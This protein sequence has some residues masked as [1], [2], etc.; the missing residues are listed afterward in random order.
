MLL[1]SHMCV[2]IHVHMHLPSSL[3]CAHTGLCT[4]MCAHAHVCVGSS[5]PIELRHPGSHPT[6]PPQ[7]QPLGSLLCTHS[8]ACMGRHLRHPCTY[9]CIHTH[10]PSNPG[11][12]QAGPPAPHGLSPGGRCEARAGRSGPGVGAGSPQWGSGGVT[13]APGHAGTPPAPPVPPAA[14]P[15]APAAAACSSLGGQRR[16]GGSRGQL[17]VGGPGSCPSLWPRRTRDPCSPGLGP[18][19]APAQARG[20]PYAPPP[21]LQRG[22][23]CWGVM[24]SEAS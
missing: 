16:T 23:P 5:L 19:A 7:S 13:P 4:H 15:L 2:P 10:V 24:M 6:P 20:A 8:A 3:A 9:V 22:N 18:R 14:A 12:S 1:C 21:R 11:P 17:G